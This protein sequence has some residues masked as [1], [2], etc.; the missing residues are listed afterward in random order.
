[1]IQAA[2]RHMFVCTPQ[3]NKE[4]V[5][6]S[7]VDLSALKTS[8]R[9]LFAAGGFRRLCQ[10]GTSLDTPKESSDLVVYLY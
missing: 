7:K 6:S 8:R 10:E 9:L 1:M 5:S 3:V 4:Q 2:C